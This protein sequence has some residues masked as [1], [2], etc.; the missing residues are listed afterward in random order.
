MGKISFFKSF[1]RKGQPHVSDEITT[2]IDFL[3][4]IK[5]GKWKDQVEKIRIEQEKS[6]RDRLKTGLPSVTISGTFVERKEENL[7]EHSGFIC[8]DIDYF[9]DKSALLED[10]YTF[11]LFK[12]ASGGGLAVIV[13]INQEKHKESYSWL[14]NYYFQSFGIVV[15]RAPSNPASL[16]F[17]SFD[18]ELFLNEKSRIGKYITA[19]PK[20]I[21]S[22]PIVIPG[23][24]VG[25]MI[26]ECI[27]LGQNIAPDYDSYYKLAFALADGFGDNGRQWFH[28]LCSVSEK[29]D[30]RHADKQYDIAL[31]GNKQGITVGTLY[32]MLKQVG[33]H[34]P[35]TDNKPLQIAAMAKKSGRNKEAV[36]QQLT[37]MNG[38]DPVQA[39]NLVDEVFKRDDISIKSASG[40]TDELIQAFFEWMQQNHPMRVNSIT[41]VIDEAGKEVKRERINSIYL[42]ARMFF[43]TKDITKDLCESYIFSDFISEYNPITEYIEKNLHRRSVGNIASL[44]KCIRSETK[45]KEVFV[46]KWFLSLIAA[47]NGHPVRSVLALCGGQN[48]GKTEWFRRLLPTGLRK[49]YAESKLDA[50]K[51]DDILMCQKL[52]VMDDE[53]GGKSKQDEKRF[54]ELT[55][56]SVFSLR[57]PY[58]RSN[59]DFKRLA[60]LC[61]TSNDHEVINDPTGN[62]R[63]LPINVVSLDHELYNSIDKDELFMEAYRAYEDGEMWQLT[64]EELA[65]LNSMSEDFESIPFERELIMKFFSP[66]TPG[67]YSEWLLSSEIKDI[68]EANTKQKITNIKKFG[69]ECKKIFGERKSKKINGVDLKRY[70][71]VRFAN[72]DPT[73]GQQSGSEISTEQ[74]DIQELPF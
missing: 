29:Y 25:E 50:G 57:A 13:R 65:E 52:I 2:V 55:S 3:N 18:P 49:Y 53:M 5:Y 72:T 38:L 36:K 43:N 33:I 19:K 54:K 63:I 56:K 40:D 35:L 11:A 41:R 26:T 4:Q 60:V 6:I 14:R 37:E 48:T 30:S 61:G 16:R 46:R 45:M 23:D 66:P 15:D 67:K 17:A 27:N 64:T 59:E 9:T 47:Y 73:V 34:A 1:P 20:K 62:T 51:D 22:L 8:I 24:T 12:S 68:I 74:A 58:A 10:P 32:W 39:E 31:K 71:L 42:R 7:I 21:H 70:E 44:A 69:I 28:S